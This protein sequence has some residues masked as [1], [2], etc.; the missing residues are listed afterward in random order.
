MAIEKFFSTP[1]ASKSFDSPIPSS[2]SNAYGRDTLKAKTKAAIGCG[3][4]ELY[5]DC[6]LDGLFV[7]LELAKRASYRALRGAE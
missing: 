6:K 2:T 7:C 1:A 3:A 5:M 4:C